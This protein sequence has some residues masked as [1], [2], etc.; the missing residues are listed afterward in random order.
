M[1]SSDSARA[2]HER[3][4][5]ELTQTPTAAGRE[6]RVVRWIERWVAERPDLALVADAAGNLVVSFQ[7]AMRGARPIWITAHLDHPAFVVE[8]IVGP[9]TAL[10]SFRGGVMDDYF[11]D[12]EVVIHDCAEVKHK[13]K[14]CGKAEGPCAAFSYYMADAEH[15]FAADVRPGNIATW[16][17][18]EAFARGGNIYTHA[19]DDLAAVAAAVAAMDVLRQRPAGPGG[20]PSLLFTR[21]E[22]IGFIG[23]IAACRLGTMPRDARVINLE[24]S[25]SFEDSPIGGGPIVRVGDRLTVFSPN[26][27]AAVAKC[28]ENLAGGAALP[29]AS[30]KNSEIN[31]GWR[32][33]RKLM[34][35]GACESTVFCAAGYDATCVCLPLGN[36]HNMADLAAVQAG[37]NATPARVG[38]EFISLSDFHGLVD[39]LVAC[40]TGLPEAGPMTERLEKLWAERAFVLD[41]R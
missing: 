8:R 9:A 37:T 32:G 41:E 26:L 38:P 1:S 19:C 30:Q 15:D 36:Y 22:E 31:K 17:L 29:T 14:L 28:A 11:M 34:A 16:D 39:L 2:D 3:W 27:T 24:N 18:P 4:L 6:Y 23:A 35:G 12:G 40:G 7:G 13:A 5:F 10:L 33:Q 20:H 25:R 21:A